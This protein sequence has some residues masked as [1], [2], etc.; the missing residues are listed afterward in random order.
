MT[1]G[2]YCPPVADP[3]PAPPFDRKR[4]RKL[5]IWGLVLLAGTLVGL[6]MTVISMVNAFGAL[7]ES[8]QADPA[9]FAGHISASLVATMIGSCVALVGGVLCGIAIFGQGN[10]ERW[11]IGN[12]M[13]LAIVNLFAFP[14][15]TLVGIVLIAGFIMRWR[16]FKPSKEVA[17]G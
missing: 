8:G 5:A 1:D 15:G 14:I 3:L 6:V 12:G 16:E 4:G 17:H 13:A 10:R 9:Q 2:I 7:A 11:F